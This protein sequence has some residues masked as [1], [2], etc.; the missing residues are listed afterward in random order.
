MSAITEAAVKERGILFSA[1]MVR[2]LMEDRKTQTRRV[3][4]HPEYEGC[5]TGDC[6]HEDKQECVDCIAEWA[7]EACPYGKVGERL[8]VRESGVLSQPYSPDQKGPWWTFK[9]G[10]QSFY[11][12]LDRNKYWPTPSP[13]T[14]EWWKEQKHKLTSA[15]FMPHWASRITL[16]ITELRIER[17][18]DITAEDAQQEGIPT[19]VVEHTF[20]KVYR[21]EQERDAKRVEYFRN[22]WDAINA[23]RGYGWDKNPWVHV[24]SFRRLM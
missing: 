16:E 23:K 11:P 20:R 12:A 21:D 5:L 19:H 4:K 15:I 6:P 17:V 13:L 7:R 8:W 9:D 14:N 2:A 24:I 3:I 10:S 1:E 18:Q 22:L